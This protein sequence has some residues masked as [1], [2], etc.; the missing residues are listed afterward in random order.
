MSVAAAVNMV[1]AKK[2]NMS[3]STTYT[4]RTTISAQNVT[5]ETLI[6]FFAFESVVF[7]IRIP[8]LF[9]LCIYPAFIILPVLFAIRTMLFRF[10][11]R[12][13]IGSMVLFLVFG[14]F[15]RH[16]KSLWRSWK[17]KVQAKGLRLAPEGME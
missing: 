9:S 11:V 13:H 12:A 8:T 14:S 17:P 5:F 16:N 15:I 1:N 3:L 2:F 6:F 4:G 7:R 10:V